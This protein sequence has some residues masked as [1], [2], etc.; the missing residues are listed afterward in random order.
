MGVDDGRHG[1]GG[2]ME[3]IHELEAQRDYERDA[4]QEEG[5]PSR[6]RRHAGRLDIE[7]ETVDREDEAAEEQP[8]EQPHREYGCI[9][10]KLRLAGRVKRL[11]CG[12]RHAVGPPIWR[13]A[14]SF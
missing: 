13:H 3:A 14:V 1:I 6:R 2:V 8:E 7:V 10:I 12:T 4:E 9:V 5:E 11:D